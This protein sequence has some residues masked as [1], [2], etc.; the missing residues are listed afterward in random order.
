MEITENGLYAAF[1][2][3]PPADEGAKGQDVAVPERAD[4]GEQV[5]EVADPAD[6]DQPGGDPETEA[7]SANH[8]DAGKPTGKEPLTPQQRHE[9]AARRREQEKQAAIEEAVALERANN[10][11]Q[12]EQLIRDLNLQNPETGEPITTMEEYQAFSRQQRDAAF[13]RKVG[14]GSLTRA[15]I[16]QIVQEQT[17]QLQT[18]SDQQAAQQAA[19]QQA[20]QRLQQELQEIQAMDASIKDFPDLLTMPG[21]DAFKAKVERGYSLIDAFK[22]VRGPELQQAQAEAARAA[23]MRN[24]AGKEHLGGTAPGRGA[25]MESVPAAELRMY[26]LLNPGV[27][28]A[29]ILRHFNK[30]RK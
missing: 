17:R 5:Q 10:Q 1:G 22:L 4:T 24:S 11:K 30:N 20:Q 3:E 25:G 18:Q 15:D 7:G 13:T 6:D 23:A 27:S 8:D 9:N 12:M 29:E 2:I 26:R 16:E 14:D 19:Q 21:A 28:D